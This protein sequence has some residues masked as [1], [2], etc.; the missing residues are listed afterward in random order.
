MNMGLKPLVMKIARKLVNAAR[1]LP[2]PNSPAAYFEGW[3][4]VY[5]CP[6][7]DILLFSRSEAR[8]LQRRSA[9]S[10]LHKRFVLIVNLE[11]SGT[12]SV[13]GAPFELQ[14]GQTHLVF[15]QSYHHFSDL[16]RS[17]ILWLLITFETAEPERLSILR[18]RTLSFDES[19]LEVFQT[20][21][22]LF[23]AG[24]NS[25]RLDLLSATLSRLLGRW[26]L[27]ARS[28]EKGQPV[29][30]S[31]KHTELWQKMQEQLETLPPEELRVGPLAVKLAISERHLRSKFQEQFGV[32]IGAY[33]RNY[34]IRRAIGLLASSDLSL[35]EIADRCGYGSSASFYR[36]FLKHTG[37]PPK[38]FRV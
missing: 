19:D 5:L 1:A 37:F 13:D 24:P 20:M 27:N 11:T 3:N 32:S 7:D 34:R 36:A 6:V 23:N 33:L 28:R 35:A 12:V 30:P 17:E 16:E 4:R 21:T 26:C 22:D 15:P 8:D 2:A 18:Q 25:E 9:E 14:P 29:T 10:H 31:R 38:D